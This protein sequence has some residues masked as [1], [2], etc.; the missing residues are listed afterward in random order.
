ML[1]A[2]AVVAASVRRRGTPIARHL[3]SKL[4]AVQHAA[5]QRVQ[6]LLRITAI[7]EP[8]IELQNYLGY[9]ID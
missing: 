8:T 3:H 6:S 7:V 4:P 2:A 1:P 5:V 9:R